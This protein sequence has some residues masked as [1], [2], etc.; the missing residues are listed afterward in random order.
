MYIVF[1]L[2]KA[3]MTAKVLNEYLKTS[4]MSRRDSVFSPVT[5]CFYFWSL[6]L[7]ISF[8]P[9]Q[10]VRCGKKLARQFGLRQY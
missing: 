6:P 2:L 3:L 8:W 1:I 7:N 10:G 4:G 5:L 9:T